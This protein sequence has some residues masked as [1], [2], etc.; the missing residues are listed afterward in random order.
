MNSV[1]TLPMCYPPARRDVSL[2]LSFPLSNAKFVAKPASLCAH[3]TKR[4][5]TDHYWTSQTLMRYCYSAISILEVKAGFVF[6]VSTTS[7]TNP[8]I[9]LQMRFQQNDQGPKPLFII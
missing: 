1:Y 7:V 8:G 2:F 6:L 4:H 3:I 9:K 5:Q